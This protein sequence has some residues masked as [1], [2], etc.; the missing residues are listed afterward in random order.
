MKKL[1]V[2]LLSLMLVGSMNA[3]MAETYEGTGNGR[4][5][6]VKVSVTFEEGKISIVEVLEQSE[7]AGVAD[8]ALAQIPAAIV[9]NQI[10]RAH[11]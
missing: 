10:G 5:G 6:A 4:N 1:V 8:G 3:A 7:T 2:I 9:G 11:V